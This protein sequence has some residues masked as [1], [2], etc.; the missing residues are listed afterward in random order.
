MVKCVSAALQ[1][2]EQNKKSLSSIEVKKKFWLA[3]KKL[4]ML[5]V[6]DPKKDFKSRDNIYG[7]IKSVHKRYSGHA[8]FRG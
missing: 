5:I 6:E 2:Q 4:I 3:A 7:K 1:A 8:V